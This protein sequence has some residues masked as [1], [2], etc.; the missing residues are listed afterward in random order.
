M[1][2]KFIKDQLWNAAWRASTQRGNIYSQNKNKDTLKKFRKDLKKDVLEFIDK[3]ID[4][5]LE[6]DLLEKMEDLSRKH[7]RNGISFKIGHSQKLLNLM[8]K[9]YWC[10]EW[11]KYIPPHC[12]IDR[13]ILIA[14]KV[15]INGKIP[16]WTK[17]NSIVEYRDMIEQIKDNED[18]QCLSEWELKEYQAIT[19]NK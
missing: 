16:A 13:Q 4:C 7:S 17:L 18:I 8:L 5:L 10:L 9:Y 12:P 14:A 6:K 15:K 11:L 2:N 19:K 3:N 1:K